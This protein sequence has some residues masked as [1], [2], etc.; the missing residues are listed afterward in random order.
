MV[1]LG[2]GRGDSR[3]WV[4][5][6]WLIVDLA[7]ASE[8]GGRLPAVPQ[9]AAELGVCPQAAARAYNE[10]IALGLVR[11]VRGAGYF[12]PGGPQVTQAPP[13][14]AQAPRQ[15]IPLEQMSADALARMRSD[16]SIT[17]ALALPGSN[18]RVTVERE[19]ARIA[20]VLAARERSPRPPRVQGDGGPFSFPRSVS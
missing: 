12:R 7:A 18:V 11:Y 8:P 19:L 16:L 10:V 4:R 13:E 14:T 17:A 3:P 9:V 15:P 6:A 2:R 5:A 1:I 20:A